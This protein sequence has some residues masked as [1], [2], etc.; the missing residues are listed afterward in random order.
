MEVPVSMAWDRLHVRARRVIAD[1]RVRP[2]LTIARPIRVVMAERV[3]MEWHP[4]RA[5]VQLVI[6]VQPARPTLT[7]ALEHLVNT[8]ERVW[9]VSIRL[10]AIVL[11]DTMGLSARPQSITAHRSIRVSTRVSASLSL[12][13]IPVNAPRFTRERRVKPTCAEVVH[14]TPI[15]RAWSCLAFRL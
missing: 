5:R 13:D 7:I 9:M 4:L 10:R 3:W 8:E 6:R 15:A 2:T 12:V 1:Q 11:M 14:R